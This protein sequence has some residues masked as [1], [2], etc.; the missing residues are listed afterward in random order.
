MPCNFLQFGDATFSNSRL[1]LSVILFYN[2]QISVCQQLP[3]H[4]CKF[5]LE[6]YG[7]SWKAK[8]D[9]PIFRKVL[10]N[11]NNSI[12]FDDC[13]ILESFVIIVLSQHSLQNAIWKLFRKKVKEEN[14]L[15]YFVTTKR[16]PANP[17]STRVAGIFFLCKLSKTRI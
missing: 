16:F 9:L 3:A 6:L 17:L 15:L 8:K 1:Q 13:S 12:L 10:L 11:S 2:K 7:I 4:E 5:F 14:K